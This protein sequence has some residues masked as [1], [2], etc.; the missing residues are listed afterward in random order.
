MISITVSNA[1]LILGSH[2]IFRDLNWEVQHDQKIGLI[3]PNG[4]G[5]S[6]LFKLIIGEHAPEK[7]GAVIKA[8]GV[9]L[10]YLPQHP[11]FEPQKTALAL[12]LE[13]N[14]RV[15][16]I[17]NELQ[18]VESKLGNPDVYNN[19]KA[20]ERA[21]DAQHKLL[22]EYE[23]LGGMNYTSR[24]RELLHGL[25]LPESDFEKPIRALSG[26]QKKLVGL[27][28]LMLA[29]PSVLLLDEPDN[30]LDMPG[31]AYLEKLILEYP[32]AV[33]IISHDRYILDAVATHIAE[34]E[35]GRIMTFTGNYTEYIL[36]K[37]ERLAR[38]EE[39][40]KTQQREIGRLE[41]AIK[42][43]ALWGKIYDNEDFARKAKSMQK[44]LDKMDKIEKPVLERRKM[45]LALNGWRGSNQ[46]LE[47]ERVKKVFSH[48]SLG[49]Q[50][51]V[52]L[53][54]INFLIRH[55][56]RVGLIGANGA[57]KSVLL[58]LILGKEHPTTGEIK[59]GP[60]V[61]V[62]YYAQEHETLN[63]SQTLIDAVRLAG[64]MSE[65]NAVS[66]L[67]RYLF[68]YQQATQRI[69]S[70]SGGERSRLQ[71][72]LLV[73]SGANFLLLDEPTN[74]LDIASAEVLENA[75]NDFNGTVLVISHDRYFL[76]R[77]VHRIFALE[78]A[79]ITEYIGGY[80]DYAVKAEVQAHGQK[81]A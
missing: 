49:T 28:Q 64:S 2:A 46:V 32:G 69:G 39:L 27:A 51:R 45:D 74:N 79:A 54:D 20:L 40:F 58:R 9:T 52:I 78:N 26:G 17:E 34:I 41:A 71:L 37:E 66:F 24:V 10:G 8:K 1:T 81:T 3:G 57:G 25:G 19:A 44:R 42:R 61:K 68:T 30:H 67:I 50:D 77:T 63:F 13:G 29:R 72:A 75:L 47:L 38:Q 76:D 31:K 15:T 60:S 65:S 70:L 33:V 7:G 14:P 48:G 62:G 35:D 6:S 55:G 22:E 43:Y 21:L 18:R 73:L 59:I 23:S 11:E 80:S 12:A 36:D 53:N 5:K 56:E 16:E 4:A